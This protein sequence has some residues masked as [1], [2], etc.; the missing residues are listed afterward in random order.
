MATHTISQTITPASNDTSTTS[1]VYTY[2][3]SSSGWVSGRL[4]QGTWK[5]SSGISTHRTGIAFFDNCNTSL[6]NS[7]ATIESITMSITTG[8]AGETGDPKNLYIYGSLLKT[9][10]KPSSYLNDA[11]VDKANG[12]LAILEG[13]FRNKTETF[14]ITQSKYPKLYNYLIQGTTNKGAL[15][16]YAGTENA[17]HYASADNGYYSDN[18]LEISSWTLTIKYTPKY[19]LTLTKTVGVDSFT[20]AGIYEPGMAATTIATASIGYHLTKYTGTT[21]DGSSTG[22][23]TG[24]ANQNTHTTDWT[25]NANRTIN[26]SGEKNIVQIGYNINGGSLNSE[27]YSK[28]E[29]NFILNSNGMW[30]F[31]TIEYGEEADPYNATTFGLSKTGY[32]FKGWNSYL[33]GVGIQDTFFDQN[34]NYDS[35]KYHSIDGINITTANATNFRCYLY[36]NWEPIKITTTFY[37]NFSSSDTTKTTQVFTYDK[38]G[39]TFG[40][41]GWTRN[42]YNLLG[43]AETQSATSKEYNEL[44]N[45]ANSW[46]LN[47][48]PSISLYAVW[49]PKTYTITYNL[50]GGTNPSSIPTSYTILSNT[51]TLPTP[52]KSGYVFNGW[53]T[54]SNFTGSKVTKIASGS[55][56]NKVYY[57]KWTA[58]NTTYTV[59][60]WKQTLEDSTQYTQDKSETLTNTAGATVTFANI[61]KD[62][63]GFTFSKSRWNGADKNSIT[64]PST[65]GTCDLYYDRNNYTVTITA[66]QG[67]DSASV[68]GNGTYKYGASVSIQATA[69]PGYDTITWTN[70]GSG[71]STN[72]NP[73]TFTMGAANR[74]YEVTANLQGFIWIYVNDIWRKAIPYI[75][76]GNNEWQQAAPYVYNGSIWKLCGE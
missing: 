37:R 42:G 29:H 26:V 40:S 9:K 24:C 67:I 23:W 4:Q 35:T 38:A 52:T 13:A 10:S 11:V 48:A 27:T 18:Y 16:I 45:V 20:G 17:T 76:T 55:T 72:N 51:I 61:A 32:N 33:S 6:L 66:G 39:Q 43:W 47:N 25:M 68:T 53:Y 58:G 21:A 44:A 69:K 1:N 41:T 34:T 22:T 7:N 74:V 59:R 12:V 28:N 3:N 64:L 73:H 19:R 54:T 31:H 57:A 15:C 56:G 8:G 63:P 46:I 71:N 2:K 65:G 60:H 30:N 50:N 62:Y 14:T 49:S 70:L 36:A 75:Y 5:T